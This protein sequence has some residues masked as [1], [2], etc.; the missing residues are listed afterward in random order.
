[1]LFSSFEFIFCFLPLVLIGSVLVARLG[2]KAIKLYLGAASLVFY[3]WWSTTFVWLLVFSIAANYAL[4]TLALHR[5]AGSRWRHRVM[6]AGIVFNL[7]ILSWFKYAGFL[8][9]NL[10]L[11]SGAHFD[12][13]AI[14]LP[15]GISFFTFQKVALLVDVNRGHVEDIA[16]PDFLLFVTF[17]PQ[18]I[19]GPIVLY[20]EVAWQFRQPGRLGVRTA[21]MQVGLTLFAIGLAKKVFLADNL[22]RFATPLF[23]AATTGKLLSAGDAWIGALA[24]TLQLYFDFSGYSDMA[25]GLAAMFGIALPVNFLSPYKSRSIIEFWRRWHVTLSHFLRVYL[26]FPL[27]GN[28]SGPVRRQMNLMIVMFLGGLWHGAAWTFVA[29]GV[30]HGFYLVVNHMWRTLVAAMGW[31]LPGVLRLPATAASWAVT[32]VAVVAAWVLFRADGF[33]A[34]WSI[35]SAMFAPSSLAALPGWA[36]QTSPIPR[37]G[38]AGNWLAGGLAVALLLPNSREL[39]GR[40]F[41]LVEA[42]ADAAL[43]APGRRLAWRPSPAWAAWAAL[44][45]VLGILGLSQPQVFIYFQ[46]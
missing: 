7:G 14:I 31:R 5:P 34:A 17:F 43:A 30:L 35:L 25:I 24:Y 18:L 29:W 26:Y 13:G 38:D 15:L 12:L 22:E 16:F 42:G 8:A 46:F 44:C 32:F 39:L 21:G 23:N 45:L 1:M 28:R 4:L 36:A 41:P 20:P 9:F 2:D 27:G 37:V 10:S 40:A 6:I 19:A 11:V 33:P 3:A